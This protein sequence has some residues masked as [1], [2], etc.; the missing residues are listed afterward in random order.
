MRL[1]TLAA[2]ALLTAGS[3]NAQDRDRLRVA[4]DATERIVARAYQGR[5]NGSEQTETFSRTVPL[6]RDG[7]VS[8]ENIGGTITVTGGSGDQVS[9]EAVKRTRGDRGQ[10]Q[11]V[12]IDIEERGGGRLDIR[13]LHAGRNTRAWVDYTITVPASASV[14]ARSISGDV[15]VTNVQGAVHGESVSGNVTMSGTPNLENAKAVSGDVSVTGVSTNGDLSMATTSGTLT[16]R[17]LKVR[18]LGVNTISGDVVLSDV[19]CDRLGVR[20]VSGGIDF[21][22]GIVASGR[23]HLSSHSGDVRLALRNPGGFELNAS[24]FSGSIR[25]DMPLVLHSDPVDRGN[26]Q[27]RRSQSMQATYGDGSALVIVRT[28]SGDIVLSER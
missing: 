17:G 28:F 13:T 10:L 22:G 2:A 15:K 19:I 25:S 5:G 16:A 14:E 24:S 6:G 21:G 23:Y 20:S 3:A 11:N 12:T 27:G 26:R 18:G 9:I 4:P 8:I 1:S 7:R